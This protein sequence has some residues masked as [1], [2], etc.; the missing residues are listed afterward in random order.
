MILQINDA[1]LKYW[2]VNKK[3]FNRTRLFITMYSMLS[4]LGPHGEETPSR[5]D[6]LMCLRIT[7][8]ILIWWCF[9]I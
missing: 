6:A 7:E 8:D 4:G 1:I 2:K 3:G 9:K 5:E